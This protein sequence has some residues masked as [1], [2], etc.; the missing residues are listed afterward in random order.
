M[1]HF[2]MPVK[3]LMI[4]GPC[5]ETSYIHSPREESF[6]FH[7]KYIDVSRTTHTNLDVKQEK[8]IDD[9][10]N[11][12]GKRDLSDSSTGFTE[13]TFIT[14]KPPE[15]YFRSGERLTKRQATSRLDHLWSELWKGFSRNAELKEKHKWSNEKPKLDNARKLRGFMSLTLR[16]RNSKK[17]STMLAR[18]WKQQRLPLCLARSARTVSMG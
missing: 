5:Q 3:R 14:E 9:Y 12:D 18:N 8:R 15:G 13:F 10:W 6:L 7:L 4:F 11:I 16:T 17:P 2:R 1:T